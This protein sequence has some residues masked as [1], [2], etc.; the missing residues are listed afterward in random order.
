MKRSKKDI[1]EHKEKLL[2]LL[3]S[4]R[5]LVTFDTGTKKHRSK[6]DYRR[7]KNWAKEVH[8]DD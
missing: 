6:K 4:S 8:N 2:K 3:A 5:V 7:E 1:K